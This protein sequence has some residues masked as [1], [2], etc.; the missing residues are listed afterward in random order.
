MS[1]SDSTQKV[2]VVED[3]NHCRDAL[4]L[5]LECEGFDVRV[6]SDG[7]EGLAI[8]YSYCPHAIVLDLV[9]PGINGF[10]TAAALKSD[11][12]TARIPIVAVTAS[13]LGSESE[14]LRQIGFDGALRKPFP[15]IALIHELNRVLEN[16]K[17]A[18]VHGLPYHSN[19]ETSSFDSLIL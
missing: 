2:L 10:D 13:W 3:D 8:V 17:S 9:L 12:S 16:R 5:V 19:L 18:P 15:G 7:G 6:A 14:R 1:Q 4:R 11:S